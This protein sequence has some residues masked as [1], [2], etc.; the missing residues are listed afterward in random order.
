MIFFY[1]SLWW[2]GCEQF[3]PDDSLKLFKLVTVTFSLSLFLLLF[4]TYYLFAYMH[5]EKSKH[6]IWK[7]HHGCA[8]DVV[9]QQRNKDNQRL[10]K[11]KW[12]ERNSAWILHFAIFFL[13]PVSSF[14]L[15]FTL[16][17]Y[18]RTTLLYFFLF[19]IAMN[20]HPL[21]LCIRWKTT[22][23]HSTCVHL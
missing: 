3:R 17:T 11:W 4:L 15:L 18:C 2:F 16:H 1:F 5:C 7:R 20:A 6:I 9:G 22:P 14:F 19:A 8:A 10:N 13:F 12:H 23:L 21:A